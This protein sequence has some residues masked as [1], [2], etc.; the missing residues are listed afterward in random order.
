MNGRRWV[1]DLLVAHCNRAW[2]HPDWEDT[3]QQWY[4]WLN[5]KKKKDGGK[6]REEEHQKLVSRTIS[7]AEGTAGS[8]HRITKAAAWRGCLQVLEELAEDA[9]PMRR[10]E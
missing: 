4:N 9:E 2:L 3:L 10:C 8:L 1:S 5:E 6:R 7:S